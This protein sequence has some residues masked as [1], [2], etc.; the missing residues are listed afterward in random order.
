MYED[1]LLESDIKWICEPGQEY[2][3]LNNKHD[4]GYKYLLSVKRVF[5]QL[6]RSFVR[7]G[8]V[9]K[10]DE[11]DI[12]RVDKSFILQDFKDKEA[13]LVYRVKMDGQEVVF[14]ILMELQSTVDFQ[15]PYRLL[16]YMVE[17]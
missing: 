7:Q 4:K 15:M 8:W 3:I 5:L 14:Y 2:D 1:D 11:S 12:I 17:I 6:L 13:D 9:D 10:I 16:L